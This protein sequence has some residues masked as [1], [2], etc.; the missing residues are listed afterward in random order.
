[1]QHRGGVGGV[2]DEDQVGVVRDQRRV[3]PEAVGLAQQDPVDP[4]PGVAQRGLRLGELRMHH[5]RP[6]RPAQGLGEQHE[7]LGGAGGEQ[8]LGRIAAVPGGDRGGRRG[9][10]RVRREVGQRL[11]DRAGQPGRQRLP[12]HVDGEIDQPVADLG[13][14]VVA[15]IVVARHPPSMPDPVPRRFAGQVGCSIRM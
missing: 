6:A 14:A 7:G 5:H 12:A 11:R 1:M 4:V 9:R 3:E 8:H 13:V 10:V 15:K 2:A